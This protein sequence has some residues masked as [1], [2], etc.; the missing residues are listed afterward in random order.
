MTV[1][2]ALLVAGSLLAYAGSALAATAQAFSPPAYSYNS[3]STN[4]TGQS[5]NTLQNGPVVSGKAFDR[6]IQIWFENTDF[7][8]AASSS[9]FQT[10]AEQGVLFTSYYAMTHPSEP[11]YIAVTG[12]DFFGNGADDFRAIPMNI[13]TVVDLLEQKNVSWASYQESMPYDGYTGYNYTS[14]D[15][16]SGSG[17]YTYYVRKHN[18]LVI[19]DSVSNVTDR[20]LRIRNFNDFARDL[21]ASVMPQWSFIT[22]NLVNDPVDPIWLNPLLADTRFNDNRTII[23]LTFDETETYSINNRVWTLALGGGLPAELKNT[24]DDTFYTHYSC[25]STNNGISANSSDIPLLNLTGTIPGPLNPEYYV[26]FSAP[27]LNAT[28]AGGGPVF[29]GPGLDTSLSAA[30][31]PAPVNLTAK[32]LDTPWAQ[33]PGYDYPNG[34]Q[35]YTSTPSASAGSWTSGLPCVRL[36]DRPGLSVL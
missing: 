6:F 11:N 13:S 5:N 17:D 9:T 28:G 29:K 26:P 1:S 3:E 23:L 18:P 31:L 8:T 21:N 35:G 14:F 10:L 20:A 22:P 25:L 24:T 34:T 7:E 32:G 33:N 15:Y 19:F 30:S 36:D 4:Y 16:I 2:Q 12:G 27:N